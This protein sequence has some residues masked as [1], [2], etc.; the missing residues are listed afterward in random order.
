MDFAS[1]VDLNTVGKIDWDIYPLKDSK[2]YQT[3][4]T[5]EPVK[6]KK[7]SSFPIKEALVIGIL[8][9]NHKVYF[10]LTKNSPSQ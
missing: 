10:S 4:G 3:L 5:L 8:H 6:E 2:F 7:N 1:I 9:E